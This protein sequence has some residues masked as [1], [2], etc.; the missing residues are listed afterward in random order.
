MAYENRETRFQLLHPHIT[1]K[2]GAAAPLSWMFQY[3][4]SPRS[5]PSKSGITKLELKN[6]LNN[7]VGDQSNIPYGKFESITIYDSDQESF[8]LKRCLTNDEKI[9]DWNIVIL[10]VENYVNGSRWYKTYIKNK[11]THLYSGRSIGN[12]DHNR[13][14]KGVVRKQS[15]NPIFMVEWTKLA[16]YEPFWIELKH[17]L[18]L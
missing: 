2:F 7:W 13:I 10:Y 8:W 15:Q 14:G 1:K 9:E 5:N 12:Y 16:T 4:K 3:K 18:N 6:T 11:H 17:I